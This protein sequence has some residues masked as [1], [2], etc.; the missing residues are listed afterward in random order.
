[1]THLLHGDSWIP[2]TLAG[3][4]EKKDK[5]FSKGRSYLYSGQPKKSLDS[6][7]LT[8]A[9]QTEKYSIHKVHLRVRKFKNKMDI[10]LKR[11]KVQVI[12]CAVSF[13][14]INF[15]LKHCSM[16]WREVF[17][18]QNK[19]TAILLYKIMWDVGP[20]SMSSHNYNHLICCNIFFWW[21]GIKEKKTDI[22]YTLF[23][24]SN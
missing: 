24:F 2:V 11:I 6:V 12:T 16:W 23:R 18:R 1:M 17:W 9:S 4:E 8:H 14:G 10:Y 20:P 15:G 22:V 7:V 19:W 13:N 3:R 5:V 21:F